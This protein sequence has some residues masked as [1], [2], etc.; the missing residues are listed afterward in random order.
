MKTNPKALEYFLENFCNY[1]LP[2]SLEGKV[3]NFTNLGLLNELI[4]ICDP[5]LILSLEFAH[6]EIVESTFDCNE[7]TT[8][9]LHDSFNL[10]VSRWYRE[11]MPVIREILSLYYSNKIVIE[12]M[13]LNPSL[14]FPKGIRLGEMNYDLLLPV[15]AQ[16][17]RYR[18]VRG[19]DH[20]VQ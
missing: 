9:E 18:I 15:I 11:S 10:L 19:D 5:N 17:R 4:T 2:G 3:P 20:E 1:L 8:V 13:N 6:S 14:P 12:S 16:G 7:L